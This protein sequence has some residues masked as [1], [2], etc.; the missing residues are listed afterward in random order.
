MSDFETAKK[1]AQDLQASYAQRDTKFKRYQDMF[2]LNATDLPSKAWIKKTI[3]TSARDAVIGTTR[4]LTATNP[5]WMIPEIKDKNDNDISSQI[6]M[7]AEA[8]WMAAGRRKKP[9]HFDMALSG[10]L[11]SEIHTI[12][13]TV[14]SMI[15]TATGKQKD[16][17]EELK[18]RTPV[19]FETVNPLN[20]YP[21]ISSLGLTAYAS[22]QQRKASDL[23]AMFGD[24]ASKQLAGKN[25]TAPIDVWE[26]INLESHYVWL[27][28]DPI[29]EDENRYPFIPVEARVIEGSD[30]FEKMED[31]RQPLLYGF[32][33]S[34][35]WDREN[36][37]YTVMFSLIF[38]AG[39]TA[40]TKYKRNSPDKDSPIMDYDSPLGTVILDQGEE[41][42]FLAKNIIDPSLRE[43]L[44]ITKNAGIESTVYRQAFG[45]PLTG[46]QPFSSLA[47]YSTAGRLPLV[48]YQRGISEA[49]A[50]AMYTGLRMLKIDGGTITLNRAIDLETRRTTGK[51][52]SSSVEFDTSILPDSFDIYAELEVTM[53]ADETQN[54]LS[55]SKLTE[56]ERPLASHRFAREKTL[57]IGQSDIMDEEI[58][59]E[60][61]YWLKAMDKY[62]EEAM[63]IQQKRMARM[64]QMQMQQQGGMPGGNPMMP[65]GGAPQMPPGAEGMIPPGGMQEMPPGMPP[66]MAGMMPPGGPPPQEGMGGGVVP[67]MA[68]MAGPR[69]PRPQEELPPLP[70]EEQM[71][72]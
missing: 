50:G 27:A 52:G 44:D 40:L 13:K 72:M 51:A 68:G 3:S 12:P 1:H 65:P 26:Y 41:F 48:P 31:T 45:E 46:N 8:I 67:G 60:K 20:G 4:L 55:A 35:M 38:A 25:P 11:F 71:M 66:D 43:A 19:I 64:Q 39:A 15:N 53:P 6:E 62:E 54:I 24:K 59:A 30:I 5:V 33:K 22:Y 36:L 23:I 16:W 61:F 34:G 28:G 63:R 7:L 29:L 57:G 70:G 10:L 14:Q 37:T 32:D 17:L 42:E 9:V 21:E 49:I 69:M 56:G 2:L 18:A 47:H 58:M